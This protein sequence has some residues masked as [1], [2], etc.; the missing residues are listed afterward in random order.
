MVT[1]GKFLSRAFVKKRLDAIQAREKVS[2]QYNHLIL[3][4]LGELAAYAGK[5]GVRLGIENREYYEAAPLEREMSS[6]FKS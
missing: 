4:C 6:F 5:K 2:E 3:G 1:D